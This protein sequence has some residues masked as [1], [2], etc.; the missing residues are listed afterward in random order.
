VFDGATGVHGLRV[1]K[2]TGGP[3]AAMTAAEVLD[4]LAADADVHEPV[5]H[6]S[7]RLADRNVLSEPWP[8]PVGA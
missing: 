3:L 5:G 4:D 2:V 1:D 7:G 6:F 8:L